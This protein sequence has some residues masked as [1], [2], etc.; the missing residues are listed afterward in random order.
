MTRRYQSLSVFAATSARSCSSSSGIHGRPVSRG[1]SVILRFLPSAPLTRCS[2]AAPACL[3]LRQRPV[4]SQA[5]WRRATP[6]AAAKETGQRG[7]A[8]AAI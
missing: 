2:T 3:S 5:A 7:N 1:L 8:K 6:S 4:F